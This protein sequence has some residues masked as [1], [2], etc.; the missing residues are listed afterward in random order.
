[1][2]MRVFKRWVGLFLIVCLL[3]SLFTVSVGAASGSTT[4]YITATGSKYHSKGCQYLSKSCY[5]ITL[6]EAI[7]RGYTRCSRCSPP[8]LTSTSSTKS[9]S[10]DTAK[11]TEEE[12]TSKINAAL[13][14]QEKSSQQEK[15]ELER[16]AKSQLKTC[17]WCCI[18]GTALL[19]WI[20]CAVQKKNRHKLLEEYK[21]Q[22][23]KEQKQWIAD[24]IKYQEQFAGRSC[25][26]IAGVPNGVELGM[27]YLPVSFNGVSCTVFMSKDHKKYHTK[28]CRYRTAFEI[29]NV[30]ELPY[31]CTPCKV[32]KP[33]T[34]AVRPE[35]IGKYQETIKLKE[36]Y[37]LDDPDI[38]YP[39]DSVSDT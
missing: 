30:Y 24:R 25:R 18:I 29:V 10:E 9:S 16:A 13:T 14:Q 22:K 11:Y 23:Q 35:W 32:C 1:M 39:A 17:I 15:L 38:P 3:S 8:K 21:E 26:E 19:L 12:L 20:V 31:G 7:D 6:E 2:F 4:V 34:V 28:D 33:F 36:K 27:D 37:L 5:D